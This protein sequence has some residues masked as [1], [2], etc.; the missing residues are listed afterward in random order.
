M[1]LA[2]SLAS[3]RGTV[4]IPLLEGKREESGIHGRVF[5]KSDNPSILQLL[6]PFVR[7]PFD[8]GLVLAIP[9]DSFA[10]L[11]DELDITA[12]GLNLDSF[13]IDEELLAAHAGTST[14]VQR[15]CRYL[16]NVLPGD[17][18]MCLANRGLLP[19]PEAFPARVSGCVKVTVPDGEQVKQDLFV[20]IGGVTP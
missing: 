10:S 19:P 12:E 16:L 7:S 6:L 3:C 14:P 11:A 15:G 2:M 20:G 8:H 17:Y 13:V 18:V 4:S 5:H 1:L 9:S